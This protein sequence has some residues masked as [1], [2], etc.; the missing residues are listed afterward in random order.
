MT[1]VMS[2]K[3]FG[4]KLHSSGWWGSNR[5]SAGGEIVAKALCTPAPTARPRARSTAA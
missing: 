4:V 2:T 1:A 3:V 5:N